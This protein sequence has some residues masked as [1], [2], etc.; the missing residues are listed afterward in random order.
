MP[1]ALSVWWCT[2]LSMHVLGTE[3]RGDNTIR[4]M[5]LGTHPCC[6]CCCCCPEC[7]VEPTPAMVPGLQGCGLDLERIVNPKQAQLP[8]LYKGHDAL[9]FTSR[10]ESWQAW[11]ARAARP[12]PCAG[13]SWPPR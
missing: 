7:Q 3:E 1:G 2:S 5:L 10:Y 9:L 4:L 13:L 12:A 11:G 6:C 8:A